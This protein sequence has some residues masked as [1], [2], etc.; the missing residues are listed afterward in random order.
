MFIVWWQMGLSR[1]VL[2]ITGT[3]TLLLVGV[4]LLTFGD[5]MLVTRA[6]M[7]DSMLEDYVMVA[8]AKGLPEK[9]VRDRHA[10]R[11]ALLPVL[12][13]FA[14]SVPYFLTG[15][16]ILEESWTDGSGSGWGSSPSSAT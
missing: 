14:V 7:D 9:E 12:S 10:A 15:L 13:R 4:V 3:L 6:A 5:V 11:T 8:R 2:D 16:I 1:H